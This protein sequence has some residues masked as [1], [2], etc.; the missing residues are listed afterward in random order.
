MSSRPKL[1]HYTSQAGL[2]G[3]AQFKSI[4]LTN[5]LF[6]NDSQE[7]FYGLEIVKRIITEKYHPYL[8][9][10][11][12]SPELRYQRYPSLFSFSLT[13]SSDLLSQ[14]R[15]YCPQ[16]GF[17]VEFNYS[18]ISKLLADNPELEIKKCVYNEA[19]IEEFVTSEIVRMSVE[20]YNK[21]KAF[22]KEKG[23]TDKG[24][25]LLPQEI[26]ERTFRNL[27]FIKHPGFSEEKEWRI[28]NKP[29][30]DQPLTT[31]RNK[32]KFRQGRSRIVPYL[33]FK[34]EYDPIFPSAILSPNNDD[35]HSIV[36]TQL[37][38]EHNNVSKSDIPYLPFI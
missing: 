37:L 8:A 9:S 3:M 22:E 7:Y 13:E 19:E 17:S 34:V 30:F 33:E 20:D 29:H 5:V 32:L 23:M 15:G 1:H 28:V 14:W 10:Q 25:G 24:L 18:A 21:R 26:L 4:W 12:D 16:G 2:I 27:P 6:M 36:A 31:F 35:P 11:L 38:L